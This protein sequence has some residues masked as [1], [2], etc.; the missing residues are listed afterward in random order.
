MRS[1]IGRL[2]KTLCPGCHRWYR[3]WRERVVTRRWYG[4]EEET[5][6]Q[7]SA[8]AVFGALYQG[9]RWGGT[10]GE[11]FSGF[12]STTE[13]IVEPYLDVIRQRATSEGFLGKVFVDLGC[14]DFR[15]AEKLL[16]LCSR[17]IGVDVVEPLIRRNQAAYPAPNV[18]FCCLDIATD[19]LPDGDVCFVRQVLQHLSNA[20]I[21]AILEKLKRYQWVF[22][23]EHY[24]SETGKTRPNV[25]KVHGGHIRAFVDSG[26]YLSEPPFRLPAEALELVLE[27]PGTELE[28]GGPAGTIRTFL[29]KPQR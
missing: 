11:F 15:V 17:C 26:V 9:N 5:N 23:T 12:G 19:E 14:G 1:V 22:I 10:D 7:R 4:R 16:P 24:P 8:A 27:V 28:E 13:T 21:S 6:R 3:R 29:Y 2:L 20:E 18:Q 25:D